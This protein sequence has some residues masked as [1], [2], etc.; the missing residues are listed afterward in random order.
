MQVDMVCGGYG[1]TRDSRFA[2]L[3]S[4]CFTLRLMRGV[5]VSE[6]RGESRG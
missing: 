6:E 2:L 3:G 4:A 5:E 1:G